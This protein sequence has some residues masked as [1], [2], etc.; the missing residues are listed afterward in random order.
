MRD[1]ISKVPTTEEARYCL[2]VEL[3][4]AK[5]AYFFAI[6]L[7][8]VAVMATAMRLLPHLDELT[9]LEWTPGR[10]YYAGGNG[11][12]PKLKNFSPGGWRHARVHL[13]DLS[14]SLSGL[15]PNLGD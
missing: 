8:E 11:G 5:T 4:A 3:D 2:V 9:L 10:S 15:L 1:H 7:E 6:T 12:G 14:I 13:K